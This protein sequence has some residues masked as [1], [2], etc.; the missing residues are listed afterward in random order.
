[1]EPSIRSNL[2]AWPSGLNSLGRKD[3]GSFCFCFYF[4]LDFRSGRAGRP[5]GATY[6]NLSL[7]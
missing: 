7:R 3:A 4:P 2:S 1:M 6:G 5:V